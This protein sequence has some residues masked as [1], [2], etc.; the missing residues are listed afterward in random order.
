MPYVEKL[1]MIKT[2]KGLHNAEIAK[3]GD[4]PLATVTRVFNGQTPNPTFETITRIAI[5]MGTSLDELAGLKQP[6]EP[7]I[8]SPIETTLISY[9]ELLK[10]KDDRIQAL[11]TEKN[12]I[13]KEKYKLAG[14]LFV[15]L[16]FLLLWFTVDILNG[17]FGYITY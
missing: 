10:E 3:L 4:L 5:A 17:S 2:E 16:G 14:V 12:K 13:R 8:P 1:K 7:P 15:L 6:D 11:E 9:S